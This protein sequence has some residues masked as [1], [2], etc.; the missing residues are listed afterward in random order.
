MKRI[1]VLALLFVESGLYRVSAGRKDGLQY[2]R[3][4]ESLHGQDQIAA[5][6]MS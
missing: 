2:G 4:R 3:C 6:R 5:S 1:A